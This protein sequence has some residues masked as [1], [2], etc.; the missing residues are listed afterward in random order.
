MS[1]TVQSQEPETLKVTIHDPSKVDLKDFKFK[2][3]KQLDKKMKRAERILS[4]DDPES[5]DEP[6]NVHLRALTSNE[7]AIL[8]QSRLSEND[9]QSLVS[10]FLEKTEKGQELETSDITGIVADKLADNNDDDGAVERFYRRLQMAV[11]KPKGVTIEWLKRRN[12]NMLD[13]MNDTIDELQIE[14]DLWL[15][16]T[17]MEEVKAEA[18]HHDDSDRVTSA[19]EQEE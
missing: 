5:P 17:E 13:I 15:L 18:R 9:I 11:I 4:F 2:T 14:N 7:E 16:Q 12:P 3:A 19:S 10:V 6:I 8:H 1:E